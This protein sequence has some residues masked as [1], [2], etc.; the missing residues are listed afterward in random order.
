MNNRYFNN[1]EDP[2]N[3]G[4]LLEGM[5]QALEDRNF[6]VL[7]GIINKALEIKSPPLLTQIHEVSVEL[8]SVGVFI[9]Y[10]QIQ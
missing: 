1:T 6:K 5:R 4:N 9:N 10:V 7:Y 8:N 3:S 2:N